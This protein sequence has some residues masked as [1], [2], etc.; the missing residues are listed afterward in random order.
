[1]L[2]GVDKRRKGQDGGADEEDDTGGGGDYGAVPRANPRSDAGDGGCFRFVPPARPRLD[3]PTP[4]LA[5]LPAG[6]CCHRSR[7]LAL[8]FVPDYWGVRWMRGCIG[9]AWNWVGQ[10]DLG[11]QCQCEELFRSSLFVMIFFP[12]TMYTYTGNC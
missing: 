1:M 10:F 5:M 4:L 11:G 6:C 8:R 9:I 12:L 3:S 7:L 2:L